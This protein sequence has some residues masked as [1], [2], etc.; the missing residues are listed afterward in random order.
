MLAVMDPDDR[1]LRT[2]TAAIGGAIAGC[3]IAIAVAGVLASISVPSFDKLV[4]PARFAIGL[5][6]GWGSARIYAWIV[7]IPFI[8]ALPLLFNRTWR[9][10]KLISAP[11]VTKLVLAAL[12]FAGS[13]AV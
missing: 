5:P 8:L 2:L 6:E 13:A 1:T 12:L 4:R 10:R 3:A 9:S 11:G 7:A